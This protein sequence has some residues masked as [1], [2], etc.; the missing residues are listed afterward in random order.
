[1]INGKM[2]SVGNII[3]KVMRNPLAQDITYEQAA[4]FVL[5]FIR[6]V[7][8]P[9][10]YTDEVK[11]LEL[12]EY[13]TYLPSNVINIRGVRYTGSNG[14]Q[15]PVAMRYATDVYHTS[16]DEYNCSTEYTYVVQNCVLVASKKEGFVDISYNSISLDEEGFPLIP[17]NESYKV[18]LEY[19]ILHKYLEPLWMMGKI[20]DKVFSY[21][22]QK[23]HFYLGQAENSMRLQGIDHLESMMNAL[24][25]III[26]DRA[27]EN[28]YKKFGE[29]QYI[30]RY[31]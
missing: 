16:H 19:F 6:L 4:E 24:N 21:I 11:S 2:V 29:K 8:V 1:M 12:N 22:E 26:N 31:N 27:H 5:E 18:G 28:F 3:W 13:K 15:T 23:R 7:N 30:K 25:R 20:Q 9:L 17:D 10:S 14:C